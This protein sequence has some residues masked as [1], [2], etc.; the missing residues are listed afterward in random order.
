MRA[1]GTLG[2]LREQQGGGRVASRDAP[3]YFVLVRSVGRE[4]RYG[5]HATGI[6][7]EETGECKNVEMDVKFSVSYARIDAALRIASL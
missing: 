5:A 1:Y 3:I 4:A 2:W 6:F 7:L